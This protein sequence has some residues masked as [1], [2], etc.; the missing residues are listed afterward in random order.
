MTPSVVDFDTM[1]ATD[2]HLT[3][4]ADNL[5]A[6]RLYLEKVPTSH[7]REHHTQEL[8]I[9]KSPRN[10]AQD[11]RGV[12]PLDNVGRCPVTGGPARS[13]IE[14]SFVRLTITQSTN[15]SSEICLSKD[16]NTW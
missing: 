5:D 13:V 3:A 12:V 8:G 11:S 2:I 16:V 15:C 7:L 4:S 1:I 9:S 10:R 6:F 14:S